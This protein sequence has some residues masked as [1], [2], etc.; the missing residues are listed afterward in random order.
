M[1]MWNRSEG[2]G[3]TGEGTRGRGMRDGGR[4]ERDGVRP[5]WVGLGRRGYH[6]IDQLAIEPINASHDTI[7]VSEESIMIRYL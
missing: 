2:K 1:W 6:M 7:L 5:C 3:T 4:H